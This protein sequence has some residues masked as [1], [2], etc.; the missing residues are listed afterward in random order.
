MSSNMTDDP[1]I[2][3]KVNQDFGFP[4]VPFTETHGKLHLQ[5]I[6]VLLLKSPSPFFCP[7]SFAGVVKDRHARDI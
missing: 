3:V 7:P 2:R 4:A 6:K 5:M 1:H